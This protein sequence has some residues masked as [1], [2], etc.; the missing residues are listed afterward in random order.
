MH[1]MRQAIQTKYHGPTNVRS[2]RVSARASSGRIMVEWDHR[3]NVEENH[4]AAAAKLADKMG[5]KE[6]MIGGGLP[7]PGYVFVFCTKERDV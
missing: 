1:Y 4:R 3:L 6:P 5:W 7:G 2:A